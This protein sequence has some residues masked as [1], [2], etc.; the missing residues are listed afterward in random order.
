VSQ[1]QLMDLLQTHLVRALPPREPIIVR[2][3]QGVVIEDVE[4]R[5]YIDLFSGI[6][7]N[8]V[9]HC[10]PE[11][12]E[13]IIHQARR[14]LHISAYYYHEL[15]LEMAKELLPLLPGGL[16]KLFYCNSGTEAVDGSVKFCK[17]FSVSKGKPGTCVVAL[18]GSF[19]GRLSLTLA[20]T[21]QRRYKA[22]LGNYVNFPG[23]IH[24]PCPYYYRYGGDLSENEFGKRCADEIADIID[25]YAQ[26]DVACVIVEP[27]MG[28]GGIIVPPDTF[29]PRLQVLCRE[30]GVPLIADE[31]QTGFGRTGRPFAC[32]LWGVEPDVMAMAKALGGGLPLGAI[33]VSDA[34]NEALE[35][36]DHFNTFFANPVSCAAGLAALRVISRER[37]W[38]RAARIGE[39]IISRLRE[40]QRE[41]PVI[42]DIRG[43]G[44]MIGVEFVKDP[45]SKEPDQRLTETVKDAMRKKG[46]LV[47]RGGMFRNVLRIQPPLIIDE[48]TAESA[49]DALITCVKES[50]RS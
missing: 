29:L 5:K 35:P 47:G 37:L 28:E 46:Y 15:E 48:N 12:V 36:G 6:S 3:A 42:G 18:R 30:R 27:I 14:F 13:A 9:G 22:K 26:G 4:G 20:L 38:E 21:G 45:S 32:Q 23:V 33:A 2:R 24:G 50:M 34:V 40:A 25:H 10:H 17:K 11:V 8:N 49:T 39:L 19:H 43:R 1:E 44:L 7:T 31:V 41:L 16:N